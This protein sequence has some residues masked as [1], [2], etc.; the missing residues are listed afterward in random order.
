MPAILASNQGLR[1]ACALFNLLDAKDRKAVVKSLPVGEMCVNR[2]AHLFVI[3][4]ANNLDDTQL[5]KKKVLHDALM[6]IDDC[7]EDINFQ[8]VI[9]AA[10][11]PLETETTAE[12]TQH[13]KPNGFLTNDDL[14][15]MSLFLEKSTSKK[16]R[17]IRSA[18]LFKIVQK[19]LEMFFEERLSYQLLDP[20][21]NRVM[22]NLFVGI[23][24]QG[25]AGSSDLVDEMV[26]Q[27]QKPFGEPHKASGVK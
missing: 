13:Y 2:I 19:P 10:L 21:P 24:A 15:I 20:K 5:T 22:K 25:E 7:V 3:H 18:E 6:K 14:Q 8:N 23:A 9:N 1:V 16:E 4:V 11:M 26:R 17:K 27:V 12:G